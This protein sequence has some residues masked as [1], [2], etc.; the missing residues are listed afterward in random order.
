MAWHKTGTVA[1]TNGSPIVTGAGTNWVGALQAGWGFVGPDGKTYEIQS[2]DSADQITLASAYSGATAAGQAYAAFPTQSMAQEMTTALQ[3]L[4]NNYQTIYDKAGQG[5]FTGDIVFDADQ[6]TGLGNPS[7]NEVALKAGSNWQMRLK[8][9]S[10]SGAAV[11]SSPLDN[12]A[13]KLLLVEAFGLGAETTP[14]LADLDDLT[15]PVGFYAVVPASTGTR[16]DGATD[17]GCAWVTRA[18]GLGIFQL[19]S[20]SYGGGLYYRSGAAVWDRWN[21]VYSTRNLIGPVSQTAG[22]PTGAVIERGSNANGDFLRFADGTQ[23]CRHAALS[24]AD[25]STW[26]TFP[27]GFVTPPR[28]IPGPVF[29]GPRS[30]T[31]HNE[32]LAGCSFNAWDM[33]GA[34]AAVDCNL[35]AFGWWF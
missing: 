9:G 4:I 27:A 10:A 35:T 24:S 20:D 23:I 12:T 5:R 3:A 8:A 21:K 28:V 13:G 34:K 15:T 2:I 32:T 16:P 11:Q 14:E 33:T 31:V 19:Y 22:D 1:V 17:Y 7:S 26:W 25:A 18:A 29:N 30:A 6:D